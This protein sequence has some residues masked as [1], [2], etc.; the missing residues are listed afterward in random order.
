[1]TG[2]DGFIGKNVVDQ[3]KNYQFSVTT[4]TRK[5]SPKSLKKIVKK[6]DII[7]H[8]A[9]E[10]RPKEI[11][12]FKIVNEELT[13]L[14]CDAIRSSKRKVSLILSSSIQAELN[15]DYGRSKLAAE[16][17]VIEMSEETGNS[18]YIYRL[19][20]VFGK[21]SKPNYNSVVAT[22]CYNIAN[23]LP[24]KISD[25]SKKLKLIYIDDLVSNFLSIIASPVQG[26]SMLTVEPEYNISLGNLAKQI[27][28][29]KQSR[30]NLITEQVGKGL[31]RALYST[32][33][34]FIPPG[35]FAYSLSQNKDN[36]GIFV[37]VL[38][39]KNSGQIS[40]FSSSPGVTRGEHYH[41]S[42]TEKF[43]VIQ[44]SAKF[45]FRNIITDEK[46]ELFSSG[47]KPEVIETIPGWAHNITNVGKNKMIVMLW[48]NE[49]FNHKFPDT[50]GCEV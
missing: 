33:L 44:G 11:S 21:W 16:E 4:F 30:E 27:K 35:E 20:N 26:V 24:L 38:K 40:Y 10:N 31:V 7:I 18:V 25:S 12:A 5:D 19:P 46:Y 49:I 42:K 29:F 14:L 37:E 2:A 47:D 17:V 41:Q 28:L 3:L 39:T 34:S 8:L 1:M 22:F 9:G 50:I 23:N 6:M 15:N 45:Q 32:Y 48:A 36:R 43:V 13:R